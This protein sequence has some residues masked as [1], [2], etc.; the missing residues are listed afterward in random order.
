MPRHFSATL[1]VMLALDPM[2]TLLALLATPLLAWAIHRSRLQLRQAA[3]RVRKADGELASAATENLSAIHL[4][5]AFTLES[6]QPI[7]APPSPSS[8]ELSTWPEPHSI[9]QPMVLAGDQPRDFDNAING[10][11]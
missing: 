5:Q 10:R 4:V 9:V 8:T 6:D 1:V 3:R 11:Q 7:A 2:F